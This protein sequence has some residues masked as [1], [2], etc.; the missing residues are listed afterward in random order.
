[1]NSRA[2]LASFF[3]RLALAAVFLYAAIASFLEPQNWV[4]YFP[5]WI[6]N[7]IPADTL[8]PIFSLYEIALSLWLFTK[9]YTF[10]AALVSGLTL[11][12]IMI[13]NLNQLDILFRDFAILFTAVALMVLSYKEK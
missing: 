2:E 1:M 5:D 7:I 10:Y 9:K 6:S 8:L 4:G 12:G 3:L 11:L 13:F